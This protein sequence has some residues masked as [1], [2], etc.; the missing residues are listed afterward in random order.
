M[1]TPPSRLAPGDT[2]GPPAAWVGNRCRLS[3]SPEA[4]RTRF[5][6]VA[7]THTK[8]HVKS[9]G[10][11]GW[12]KSRVHRSARSKLISDLWADLPT[13]KVAQKSVEEGGEPVRLVRRTTFGASEFTMGNMGYRLDSE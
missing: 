7:S 11:M 13:W 6:G 2:W 9:E 3:V 5:S 12:T 10:E 4:A 1:A 8:F